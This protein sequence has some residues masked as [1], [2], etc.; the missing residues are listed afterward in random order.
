MRRSLAVVCSFH[1]KMFCAVRSSYCTHL[2]MPYR[3][4]AG[5]GM[6]GVCSG[7]VCSYAII[8]RVCHAPLP[9]SMTS[10]LFF[11]MSGPV[12]GPVETCHHQYMNVITNR[13]RGLPAF[14]L[15]HASDG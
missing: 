13:D 5:A 8:A 1:L 7:P 4:L 15:L 9:M 12:P 14:R 3:T 10:P 11:S 2:D 6:R